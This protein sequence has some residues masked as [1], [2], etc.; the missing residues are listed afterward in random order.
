M[1]K[2]IFLLFMEQEN[3]KNND[4][5]RKQEE[6]DNKKEEVEK[7][8]EKL[9]KI[10]Q[11]E[12]Q[13]EKNE[14]PTPDNKKKEESSNLYKESSEPFMQVITKELITC[15][16]KLYLENKEDVESFESEEKRYTIKDSRILIVIRK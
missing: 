14:S 3:N 9:D 1:N 10:E 12:S 11:N 16:T 15:L 8:T 5:T 7:Q 13:N 2:N 6:N 4:I